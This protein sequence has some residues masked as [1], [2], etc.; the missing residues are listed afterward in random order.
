MLTITP[1]AQLN[2]ALAGIFTICIRVAMSHAHL[3][4]LGR[5]HSGLSSCADIHPK[6]QTY[7]RCVTA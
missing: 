3:I 7:A 4:G 6:I 1:S 5:P 2:P